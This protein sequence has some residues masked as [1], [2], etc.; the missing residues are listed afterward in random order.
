MNRR[1]GGGGP[2]IERASADDLMQL[3]ADVGPVREQVGAVVVL[4]ARDGLDAGH[5][6]QAAADRLGSVSRLRQVL[7]RTPFGCGRPIWVDDPGFDPRRHVTVVPCLGSG[8]ETAMLAQ[9]VRLVA[10]PLPA[11]MPPWRAVVV[12]GL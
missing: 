3:A 7:T 10:T 2:V 6:A 9:A 5:A 1:A 4:D 12:T 11:A 8:D